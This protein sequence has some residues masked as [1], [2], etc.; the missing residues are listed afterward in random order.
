MRIVDLRN[1]EYQT[2]EELIKLIKRS[3]MEIEQ[4]ETAV[5]DIIKNVKEKGDEALIDYTELFDKVKLSSPEELVITFDELEKAYDQLDDDTKWALEV[6]LER[7]KS[8]HEAQIERSYLLEEEGMLLGQKVIPMERVGLYV[9]GGKAAYPSTVIMN[10]APAKVAGVKEMVMCSPNPNKYTL[11]AAFL[12]GVDTVYR[13]G[14]AQ[15]IAAMAYGTETVKKV[16]KIVGPGNIFVALAKKN[17]YGIVDIDSIAG[18]SEILVIADETANP[19]WVA[20][21]LLSQAEHDELAASI[22]V[23]TS[24]DLAI[25]VKNILY[26]VLLKD[27]EREEIARKSLDNYG[28]IFIVDDLDTA[29]EVSN[30]I[31][32][33]HLEIIT[34][35]PFD[36]LEK[37]KH[38]GAIF[39]GEYSTEPLGDY[40]LG[41]N[42]VLPTG[43]SARFSS[44]LGVYD[45][46]KRS[47]I[48]YVSRE[49]FDRVEKYA[50]Q[51]AT[52]EGLYAHRLSVEVRKR[53]S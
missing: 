20:A 37:I 14:G 1:R 36:L 12:C 30:F 24:E 39:L 23:T 21:D 43:R 25:D 31:A 53:S 35:S 32:P 10:A 28:H 2:N 47:S 5:K 8:F 15:A 27:F 33:E 49:G 7:V 9:P 34:K 41:P 42:H 13:I 46:I 6:A 44:P 11:A 18:P 48:I 38:A 17:V 19:E 51:I 3:E 26:N 16:D 29:C 52:A 40:I 50:R 45:F 22:L 4:Y